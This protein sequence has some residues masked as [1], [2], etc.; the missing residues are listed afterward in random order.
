MKSQNRKVQQIFLE[1]TESNTH[2]I[3]P[4]C[5]CSYRLYSQYLE[6]RNNPNILPQVNDQTGG[7]TCTPQNATQPQKGMN[8]WYTKQLG[9]SSGELCWVKKKK[10]S[11]KSFSFFHMRILLST[12]PDIKKVYRN[13]R[14]CRSFHYYV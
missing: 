10:I 8:H 14:Q 3:R 2:K 4:F 11:K 7:A 6:I 13:L 1:K 9:R 12:K 5:C